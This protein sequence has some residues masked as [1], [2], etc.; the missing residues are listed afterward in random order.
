MRY[1]SLSLFPRVGK[2]SFEEGNEQPS[3]TQQAAESDSEVVGPKNN[4]P[5][6]HDGTTPWRTELDK[7][8]LLREE[9]PQLKH[10]SQCHYC[11]HCLSL[12]VQAAV[13]WTVRNLQMTSGN[14]YLPVLSHMRITLLWNLRRTNYEK[15]KITLPVYMYNCFFYWK[16]RPILNRLPVISNALCWRLSWLPLAKSTISTF[17]HSL[18]VLSSNFCD[19]LHLAIIPP[20]CSTLR[21][22]NHIFVCIRWSEKESRY[23]T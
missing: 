17:W 5:T 18:F 21:Q 12:S 13:L 16:S 10:P 7:G 14:M 22:I 15:K 2:L 23:K 9:H 20:N 4:S 19:T 1:F 11:C 6:L 3:A 8:S